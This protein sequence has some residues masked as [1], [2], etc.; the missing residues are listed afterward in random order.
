MKKQLDNI[1]KKYPIINKW[2]KHLRTFTL[3]GFDGVA[4]YVVMKFLLSEMK[5]DLIPTRARSISYSF[6]IAFFPAIIFLFTLLPYIP[7]DGLQVRL[8]EIINEVLPPNI[9]QNFI[10]VTID[11]LLNKPRGGLLSF[12]SVLTLFFS[13]QG[14]LSMLN[15]FNKTYSI[16]NNRNYFQKRWLAV[17]LTVVLFMLFITSIVLLIVGNLLIDNLNEWFNIESSIS[18]FMI[19]ALRYIVILLLYLISISTLY[20]YGPAVKKK[21]RFI[22]VGSTLATIGSIVASLI[23]TSYVAGMDKYNTIYGFFGSI[24]MFLSWMYVNAFVLLVGFELNA[25]IYYNKILKKTDD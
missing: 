5:K 10:L 8:I 25:S 23:F 18:V 14:V 2:I 19:N 24:I 20:Y 11:D 7:L 4:V 9:V 3:P 16:Y 12:A 6:F 21:F 13:T 1:I 17:K 22:S 15:S